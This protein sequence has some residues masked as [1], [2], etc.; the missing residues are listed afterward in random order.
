MAMRVAW[1]Q[2]HFADIKNLWCLPPDFAV[3]GYRYKIKHDIYSNR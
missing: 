2:Q 3:S 1:T